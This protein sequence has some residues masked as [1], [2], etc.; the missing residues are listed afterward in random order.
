MGHVFAL[1]VVSIVL[2]PTFAEYINYCY[3]FMTADM[4]WLNAFIG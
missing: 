4:P 2:Y 3:G 1:K